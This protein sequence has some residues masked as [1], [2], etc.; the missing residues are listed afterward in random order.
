VFDWIREPIGVY[1]EPLNGPRIED[2]LV[3][4]A[5]R[6]NPKYGGFSLSIPTADLNRLFRLVPGE[7]AGL[8]DTPHEAPSNN[9]W[10]G[11]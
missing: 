3:S 9:R 7:Q 1:A 5:D 10:R 11:P 4:E 2:L 8:P 6:K